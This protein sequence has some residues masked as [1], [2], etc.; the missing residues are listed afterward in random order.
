MRPNFLIIGTAKAGTTSL[1][2]SLN[3]HPDVFVSGP[4][5]VHFF[6]F[7]ELYSRGPEWYET[8]FAEARGC[9]AVGEKSN[10]YT[11]RR[12]YPEAPRRIAEYDPS[13]KLI[14]MVRHPLKRIESLWVEMRS[15]RGPR[16]IPHLELVFLNKNEVIHHSFDRA[17]RENREFLVDSANYWSELGVYRELFPDDQILVLFLEDFR[18]DPDRELKRC[19]EFLDVDPISVEDPSS[20][21]ANR[22]KDKRVPTR[23]L[24]MVRSLPWYGAWSELIPGRVKRLGYRFLKAPARKP[25]WQDS[26]RAF[27]V[28]RLRE[29][30]ER[31]LQSCGRPTDFWDLGA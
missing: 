12:H 28:D 11:V 25:D 6:S 9:R 5:E 29:D 17:V 2:L 7:D 10:S 19:F 26:T 27:V 30:T 3:E 31:F 20:T 24:S 18:K 14:Y 1:S 21:H 4:D 13:T 16:S 8:L 23:T 22:S 15:W